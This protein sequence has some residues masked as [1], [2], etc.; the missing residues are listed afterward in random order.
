MT[1]SAR[2]ERH[3]VD[4]VAQAVRRIERDIGGREAK[5]PPAL[6][7]FHDLAL[8]EVRPAEQA[9]GETHVAAL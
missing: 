6:R 5:R 8:D 3:G 4:A 2:L 9:S 7:A 1:L